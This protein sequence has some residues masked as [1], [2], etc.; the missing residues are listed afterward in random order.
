M[1]FV[2]FFVCLFYCKKKLNRGCVDGIWPIP[3]FLRFFVFFFNLTRPLIMLRYISTTT[4][5]CYLELLYNPCT[6]VIC[7]IRLNPVC[8]PVN[9]YMIRS[10]ALSKCIFTQLKLCLAT[11]THNCKWVKM[12]HCTLFSLKRHNQDKIIQYVHKM[13][14]CP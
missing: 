8:T 4:P 11:A 12:A 3:V 1:F 5:I 9:H 7:L 14:T 6:K 13:G 10:A 2:C